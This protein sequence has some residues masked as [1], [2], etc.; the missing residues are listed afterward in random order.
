MRE[1]EIELDYFV[2]SDLSRIG[3]GNR[4]V[5]RIACINSRVGQSEAAIIERR[6]TESV[7]ERPERFALEVAVSAAL[8]R[9]VLEVGQLMSIFI[10]GNGKTSGRII[11]PAQSLSNCCPALLAGVP[12]FEDGVRVLL[13]PVRS[14]SA[15]VHEHD[16]KGLAG[17][18]HRLHQVLFWFGQVETGAISTEKAGQFNRHLLA[19]EAA[20]DSDNRDNN[21]RV[22][23]SSDGCGIR[24]IVH[25]SPDELRFNLAIPKMAIS[26]IEFY[27]VSFFQMNL[28]EARTIATGA[29]D[30]FVING[31]TGETIGLDS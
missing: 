9:I 3:N 30:L 22:P 29:G 20:R 19:F 5:Q 7:S 12:G 10:E 1:L 21:V 25:R 13:L 6:V 28:S 8:H 31:N 26:D 11:L 14:Q 16:D 27:S 15:A 18:S 4:C 2:A 24:R 17:C 23:R